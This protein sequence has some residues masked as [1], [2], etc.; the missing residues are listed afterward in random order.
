MYVCVYVCAYI[1][2][3]THVH[4]YSH[5]YVYAQRQRFLQH[6]LKPC[7]SSAFWGLINDVV[8]GDVGL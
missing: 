2:T 5:M 4:I 6:K 7:H 8:N 1:C 3:N